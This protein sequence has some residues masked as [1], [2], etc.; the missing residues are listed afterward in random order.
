MTERRDPDG[1]RG[2]RPTGGRTDG[3]PAGAWDRWTLAIVAVGL[4]TA[5]IAFSFFAYV[6]PRVPRPHSTEEWTAWV[7]GTGPWRVGLPLPVSGL[8]TTF[9]A[10][11]QNLTL[12]VNGSA[13]AETTDRGR[14]LVVD[15]TG[16]VSLR[17]FSIQ[18]PTGGNGCCAEDF[19]YAQWTV[20]LG[21]SIP[22]GSV[23]L[24][25]W[26]PAGPVDAGVRYEAS[27]DYCGRDAGFQGVAPGG[28]WAGL[29]GTDS[30]VCT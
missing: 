5:L 2:S 28:G 9:E 12:S 15:G 11:L 30:S 6:A 22:F 10:W 23:A 24:Q 4:A 18:F 8:A 20:P 1:P 21:I 25:V 19:L 14:V 7:N 16:N 27:S 26:A 29:D 3:R 13:H 17:S